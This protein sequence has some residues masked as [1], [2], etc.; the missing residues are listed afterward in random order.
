VTSIGNGSAVETATTVELRMPARAENVALARLALSGV[1]AVAGIAADDVADLKLAVSE[2]CTNAVLHAYPDEREDG[3]IVVRYTV[4][5]DAVTVEVVDGGVG[6]DPADV[7][8]SPARHESESQMGLAIARAVTDELE[9]DSGPA[10]TRVAFS[11]R[12]V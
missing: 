2:A 12:R 4:G 9:I 8:M 7:T 11:K 3:E 10:G 1:A 6:F 5:A